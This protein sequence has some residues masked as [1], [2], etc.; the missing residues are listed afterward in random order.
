[1]FE[2]EYIF[3]NLP[4]NPAWVGSFYERLAEEGVWD[5]DEFWK[6]HLALINAANKLASQSSI[7]CELASAVARIQSCVWGL[8][9]AHYDENDVFTIGNLTA[10]ELY[11][12]TERFDHAILGVFSG[13]VIPE[14]SYDLNNPLICDASKPSSR[15]R[16]HKV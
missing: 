16:T 2:R 12:F 13:E 8:I 3:K 1:M 11:D 15:H 9:A 4:G 5:K 6:L 14:A 10:T 7:D